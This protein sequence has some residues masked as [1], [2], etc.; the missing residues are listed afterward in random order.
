MMLIES[1]VGTH[2]ISLELSRL[3]RRLLEEGERNPQEILA[4]VED[5]RN[6]AGEIDELERREGELLAR[7]EGI[8]LLLDNKRSDLGYAE[9][10]LCD[11]DSVN[12]HFVE[13]EEL[14]VEVVDDNFDDEPEA[15]ESLPDPSSRG[16]Y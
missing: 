10:L 1:I 4:R 5:I 16:R 3:A 2:G 9:Q 15:V 11:L 14:V 12:E 8:R 6:D 7:L 13:I